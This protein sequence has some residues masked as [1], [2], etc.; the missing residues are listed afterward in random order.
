VHDASSLENPAAMKPAAQIPDADLEQAL[1]GSR[2]HEDAPEHVVQRAIGLWQPKAAASGV[3]GLLQR[4][5][6]VLNFDSGESSPLALGLRS[7]ESSRQMLFTCGEHDL[8]LR[9][10][11][12][13]DGWQLR[14]QV[15]GPGS[16]GGRAELADPAGQMPP[17]RAALS[18]LAEFEF[19][20]VSAGRWQLR[21]QLDGN[22]SIEL[23]PIDVGSPA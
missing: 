20:P 11:L 6:G 18:E 12:Q 1:G 14:G 17:R 22:L 3:P 7:T 2:R 19:E 16:V 21:L 8:D 13:A 23:P 4:V 15:L 9:W 10:T 5:L